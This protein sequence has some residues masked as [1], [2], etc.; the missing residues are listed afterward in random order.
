MCYTYGLWKVI[1]NSASSIYE[2]VTELL[3]LPPRRAP[4][5]NSRSA[6]IAFGDLHCLPALIL[7][8]LRR[9]LYWFYE[10]IFLYPEKIVK[11]QMVQ[12]NT[13]RC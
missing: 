2:G 1:D 12:K 13:L 9:Y 8:L 3:T 4:A 6:A 11:K 5:G 10:T 7:T